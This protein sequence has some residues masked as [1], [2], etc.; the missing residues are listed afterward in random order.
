[1][2]ACHCTGTG[3]SSL[4]IG[5]PQSVHWSSPGSDG[6]SSGAGGLVLPHSGHFGLELRKWTSDITEF[7]VEQ[8]RDDLCALHRFCERS[9][10]E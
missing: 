9:G 6:V 1:M 7:K 10:F 3:V 2:V 5:W 4:G 8:K